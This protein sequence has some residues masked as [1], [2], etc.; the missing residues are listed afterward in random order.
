MSDKELRQEVMDEFKFDPSLNCDHIAVAA[1]GGVVTLSGH[2][3][4]YGQRVAAERAARRVKDVRALTLELEVRLP[5]DVAVADDENARRAR[6][7]L[8]WNSMLPCNGIQATVNKGWITLTG[9]VDWQYQRGAAEDAVR[10]LPGVVAVIDN[11]S[12]RPHVQVEQVKRKI[13]YALKRNAEFETERIDVA[14]S[15]DTVTLI[16]QVHSHEEQEVVKS[17][18]LSAPG[19]KRVEDCL[20]IG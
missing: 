20:V 12:I 6:H 3:S 19:V 8:S 4:S 2:V 7:I 14:V 16:G 1:S 13:V 10:P 15:G 11:I 17:A 5:E 18:A 9:E